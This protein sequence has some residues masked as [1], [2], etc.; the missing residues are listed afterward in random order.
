MYLPKVQFQLV[1]L[2]EKQK[3]QQMKDAVHQ[4]RIYLELLVLVVLLVLMLIIY[5]PFA[6]ILVTLNKLL[7]MLVP[8]VRALKAIK[9]RIRAKILKALAGRL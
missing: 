1:D 2:E 5:L 4:L 8:C 6:T 3:E 9:Q 7:K